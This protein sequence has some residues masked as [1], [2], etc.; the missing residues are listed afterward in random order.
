[1]RFK[2]VIQPTNRNQSNRYALELNNYRQSTETFTE[3]WT[4]LKRRF[5]LAR[6]SFSRMC[7]DHKDCAGCKQRYWEVELMSKIY[8]GVRDQR[9][10]ELIDQLPEEQHKLT[11]YVEIGECY[12]ASLA[13]AQ[14]FSTMA[15]TTI[16]AVR[17]QTDNKGQFKMPKVWKTSQQGR[18]QSTKG[19]VSQ[20]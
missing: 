3:F 10:R 4:E 13:S 15:T 18:M 2:L 14:T 20:V 1:M 19:K 17:R 6:D 12:E 5:T 7:E 16:S 11:R 8:I 9:I